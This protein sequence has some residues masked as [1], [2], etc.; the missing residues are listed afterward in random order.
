MEVGVSEECGLAP[1]T[2]RP[3]VR[4]MI[5][6]E[7]RDEDDRGENK[8]QVV[9]HGNLAKALPSLHDGASSAVLF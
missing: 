3:E 5:L 8:E 6:N 4:P 9:T 7:Q 2:L 1:G